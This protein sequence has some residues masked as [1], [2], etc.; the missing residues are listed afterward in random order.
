[1][2]N[3]WA[4][5]FPA[6]RD[7]IL[8]GLLEE[9][10][11]HWHE[12]GTMAREPGGFWTVA[13]YEDVLTVKRNPA[14]FSNFETISFGMTPGTFDYEVGFRRLSNNDG[15]YHDTI[16]KLCSLHL[17]PSMLAEM[18][19]PL[20]T[21][22]S[23]GLD[24]LEERLRSGDTVDLVRG[25]AYRYPAFAVGLL[26][27]MPEDALDRMADGYEA[28][29]PPGEADL[30]EVF[31]KLVRS[32]VASPAADLTS[33]LVRAAKADD[34]FLQLDALMYN[35]AG[36]YL[37]GHLT[38]THLQAWSVVE[39]HRH[40]AVAEELREDP[41][42]IPGFIEETLRLNP[43]VVST[44]N[45]VRSETGIGGQT[46]SPGQH[47]YSIYAAANRDPRQF[48]DPAKF[49]VRRSPNSHMS[50]SHGAHFCLGAPL[51]RLET[52]VMLEDLLRRNLD[53]V[54]DM[55]AAVLMQNNFASLPI[56]LVPG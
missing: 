56:R 4:P 27:G 26:L 54:P 35:L 16:R 40:P 14:V 53:I 44:F 52:R 51:A 23:A 25:F 46:M 39:L 41:G 12:A 6:R 29:S 2:Y 20:A 22:A 32:R 9:A 49:D 19:A 50:F 13:R 11:V 42:L 47:V 43:P 48:P 10:P 24:Q 15:L 3:V 45:T 28:G 33:E 55:E 34:T 7:E 21:K 17:R 18:G 36:F 31:S 5:D 37:A 38:T 8:Q 30:E 1:M